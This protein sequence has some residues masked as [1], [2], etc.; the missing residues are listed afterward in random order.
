MQASTPSGCIFENSIAIALFPQPVQP[1]ERLR[2][3]MGLQAQAFAPC[4]DLKH[5]QP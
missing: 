5:G 2:I 4:Q 3:E 1:T